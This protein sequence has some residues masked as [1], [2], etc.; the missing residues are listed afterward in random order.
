M[1]CYSIIISKGH[2]GTGSSAR[3][4]TPAQ[5]YTIRKI[6][7]NIDIN[8]K[9]KIYATKRQSSSVK[10]DSLSILL[11]KLFSKAIK[12]QERR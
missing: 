6:I 2:T 10:K 3:I 5:Y 4:T 9:L 11:I 1:Q 7:L 12:H 8:K